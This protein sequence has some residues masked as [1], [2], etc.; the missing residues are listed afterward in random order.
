[1]VRRDFFR[2][3][4]A[5]LPLLK[6]GFPP[7]FFSPLGPFRQWLPAT[8]YLASCHSQAVADLEGTPN[9]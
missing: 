9:R 6:R 2:D 5:S 7:D 1:M 8:I 4:K 3:A